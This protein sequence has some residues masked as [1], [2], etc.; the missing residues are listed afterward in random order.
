MAG[1]GRS[2]ARAGITCGAVMMSEPAVEFASG[3]EAETLTLGRAL[4]EL[5]VSRDVV[6]LEG[7]LGAGKTLFVRGLAAGAGSSD[8]VASPTFALIHEYTVPPPGPLRR[9]YHMDLYR[10]GSVAEAR[11]LGLDE[12]LAGDGAVVI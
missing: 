5:L 4:G 7:A 3:D 10:V 11:G 2:R 8:E 12:Y 1:C 9:L 6:L